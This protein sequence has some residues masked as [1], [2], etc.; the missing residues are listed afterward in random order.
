MAVLCS[1]LTEPTGDLLHKCAPAVA[2]LSP[3]VCVCVRTVH[4]KVAT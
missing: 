2:K 4:V 1:L 3:K